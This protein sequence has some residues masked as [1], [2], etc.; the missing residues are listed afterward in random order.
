VSQVTGALAESGFDV[1]D[2]GSQVAGSV[3]A[4]IYVLIIEGVAQQ[5]EEVIHQA[6]QPLSENI[7]FRV[8]EIETLIG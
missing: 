2:L 6:L 5:G 8:E 3:S 7:E 1:T 4:P